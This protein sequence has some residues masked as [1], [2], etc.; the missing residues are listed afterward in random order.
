MRRVVSIL[1]RSTLWL[2]ARRGKRKIDA[3]VY[4]FLFSRQMP[5]ERCPHKPL[6][7]IHPDHGSFRVNSNT[8]PALRSVWISLSVL[9]SAASASAR[10]APTP[11]VTAQGLFPGKCFLS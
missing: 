5:P 11:P 2:A 8:L 9:A 3:C 10:V 7:D 6:V 1:L 4:C